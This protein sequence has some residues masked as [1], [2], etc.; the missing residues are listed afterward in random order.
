[1]F[2]K[3]CLILSI[4][5][6]FV[7]INAATQCKFPPS[8]IYIVFQ[9]MHMAHLWRLTPL[10]PSSF[11]GTQKYQQYDI[12]VVVVYPYNLLIL[13]QFILSNSSAF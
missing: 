4:E 3:S 10:A 13:K 5:V 2:N 7:D 6:I 9:S 8:V 11:P 12:I 1:M